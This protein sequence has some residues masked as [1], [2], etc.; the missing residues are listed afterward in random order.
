LT[1]VPKSPDLGVEKLHLVIEP[2]SFQILQC[3]FTDN[4]GNLTRIRFRNIRTNSR[5]PDHLFSFKPPRGVEIH[6]V[7]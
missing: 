1:L 4:F 7:P 5:L 2:A 3:S 6:K